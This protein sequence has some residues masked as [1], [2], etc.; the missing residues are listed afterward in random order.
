MNYLILLIGFIKK[1]QLLNNLM[2]K[3]YIVSLKKK[4]GN[5][6][7]YKTILIIRLR[8]ILYYFTKDL[9]FKTNKN[10][11]NNFRSGYDRCVSYSNAS[12]IT[13]NWS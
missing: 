12:P 2:K 1:M 6:K 8:F 3:Q 9:N 10:E 11:K 13:T 5:S 7:T 4:N